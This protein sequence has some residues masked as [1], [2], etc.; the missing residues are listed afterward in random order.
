M[1]ALLLEAHRAAIAAA[2]RPTL[3]GS[4]T[5][6]TGA[7]GTTCGAAMSTGFPPADGLIVESVA[8]LSTDGV[9]ELI[10]IT[11]KESNPSVLML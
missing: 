7:D 4:G 1:T 8:K 10:S 11:I 9:A 3:P 2:V 6:L 5:P